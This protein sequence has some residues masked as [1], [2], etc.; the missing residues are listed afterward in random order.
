MTIRGATVPRLGLGT[1]QLRGSACENAV[2][3]ALELGYRHID[4][5]RMYR[6]E[7][8]VGRA[9]AESFVPRTELYVTTKVPPESLAPDQ[10]TDVVETSVKKLQCDYIDNVLLHWPSDEHPPEPSLDALLACQERGLVRHIGVSNYTPSL[11][12]RSVAHTRQVVN[13]QVEFHVYLEQEALLAQCVEQDAY[14]TA[15]SPLARGQVMDDPV[16]RGI[17]DAHDASPAQIA[18]AWLLARERVAVIPK[19][20]SRAHLLANFAAQSIALTPD[21]VARIDALP[22]NN[23]LIDPPFAPDWEP[24]AASLA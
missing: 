17:A 20:T 9:L 1:W 16:L 4:T 22:K 24:R 5:A 13:N 6:N 14:L 2:S 3:M 11:F 18:L 10:V 8:H 23:R 15:Y 19:A 21:E 12:A 7:E